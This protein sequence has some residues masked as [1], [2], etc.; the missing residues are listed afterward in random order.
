MSRS[1]L[2]AGAVAVLA[3]AAFY[4]WPLVA[5]AQRS[6]SGVAGRAGLS[7]GSVGDVFSDPRIGRLALISVGQCVVSTLLVTVLGV[8]VA[9]V[10]ARLR[11]RGR[12][13]MSAMVMVPFVLPTLT[14]AGAMIA[15]AGGLPRSQW[16][17]LAL[18]I[19]AH[20][21][22]NLG[23]MVRSVS[24]AISAVP[25]SLEQAAATLG[26]SPVRAALGTTI[27]AVRGAIASAAIIV[28][29]FCLTSF[30]VIVAL[31]GASIGT[32][33][34]EI[35][36][37]TTRTLDLGR[38]A[39]LAG[40]QLVVVMVLVFA[41]Q[42]IRSE[43]FGRAAHPARPLRTSLD[44]RLVAGCWAIVGVVSGLPIAALVVRSLR[45]PDGWTWSN[46]G[47]IVSAGELGRAGGTGGV[48]GLDALGYTLGAALVATVVAL[49]VSIPVAV[50]ASRDD[51]V[52]RWFEHAM[53]VPLAMSA[54]TLGFGFLVAFSGPT[55]DLRGRW[56]F[57]PLVQAAAA[58]PIVVRVVLG[59]VRG[60]DRSL[61]DAAAV[62]GAGP[63]RR[64]VAVIWP[65]VRRPAGV[66]AGFAFAMSVG[67]FGATVFLSRQ[68]QP[69]VAIL[70]GRLLGRPGETNLGQAMALSV[71]LGLIAAVSVVVVDRS[72]SDGPT[73]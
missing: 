53:I 65:A 63:W 70:I 43:R 68:N 5:I 9:W 37:L 29:V 11:F 62:S 67:E 21:S 12:R 27:S 8:P 17:R 4:G 69:T 3:G 16:V 58:I 60:V 50:V 59:A 26:R 19:A 51:R 44:R 55:L 1:R 41:Y 49:A 15:V 31:G 10:L 7:M 33:E 2:I 39:V 52:G 57:V 36:F 73:F 13:A 34:V 48:R 47:V 20:V 14:M 32:I 54:A 25:P 28:A 45:G 40:T 24:A 71:V 18:I 64:L 56:I 42:R 6:L 72:M 22:F 66:A 46:Y 23:I 35:W 30:G 38:A 61:L